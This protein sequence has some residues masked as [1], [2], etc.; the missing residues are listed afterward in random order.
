[1]YIMAITGGIE[2]PS[3]LPFA[4]WD[5]MVFNSTHYNN[6]REFVNEETGERVD[7]LKVNADG[8]MTTV[9]SYFD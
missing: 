6:I 1:M 7:I 9:E 2:E 4:D 8:T 3:F 5:E